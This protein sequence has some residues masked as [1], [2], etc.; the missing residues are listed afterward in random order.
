VDHEAPL[1]AVV[2]VATVGA[3]LRAAR[4]EAGVA[5]RQE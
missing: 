5:L 4:I 1:G 2:G 3:A